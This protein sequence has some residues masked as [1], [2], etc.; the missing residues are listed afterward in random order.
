MKISIK[1]NNIEIV[2][3]DN[4]NDTTIKYSNLELI[5]MLEEMSLE[6]QAIQN[7]HYKSL[8]EPQPQN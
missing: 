8:E 7:N 6:I 3:D 1:H 5:K 2:V 4:N